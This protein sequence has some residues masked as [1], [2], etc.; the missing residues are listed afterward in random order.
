MK[1]TGVI[2]FHRADNYGAVLQ[3]YASVYFLRSLGVDAELIDYRCE[4]MEMLYQ[5]YRQKSN[6][7]IHRIKIIVHDSM[8]IPRRNRFKRFRRKI[9]RLSKPY[10]ARTI[11][12][13][14]QVYDAFITGSDQVF[15]HI[16]ACDDAVYCLNFVRDG[17]I[18][19]SFAASFGFDYIPEEKRAFYHDS[20]EKFTAI[21]VRETQGVQIIRDLLGIEAERT[22][23]PT[24]I[25]SREEWD[26]VAKLPKEENYILV[27]LLNARNDILQFARE[28]AIKTGRKIINITDENR[29]VIDATYVHNAGPAEF[30]GYYHNAACVI[31]NSFHGFAFSQI[32]EKPV[33]IDIP[34]GAERT[35]SRITSLAEL[36]GVTS[37]YIEKNPTQEMDYT[38]VRM[39]IE[40]ERKKATAFFMNV[41]E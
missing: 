37:R 8:R 19:T 12:E 20:L 34:K 28:L 32:Y 1:K 11:A 33:Y 3:A 24:M 22:I 15:N 25:L 27:Y 7:F 36:L 38:D 39:K 6:S 14:N 23:D 29:K 40:V 9:L 2:T 10:F 17:K 21:S 41:L 4:P 13:S 31:T 16:C 30:L 5:L 26:K 18:R 35:Y